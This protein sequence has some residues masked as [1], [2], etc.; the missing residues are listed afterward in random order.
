M[1]VSPI[2]SSAVTVKLN[3]VPAV[4]VAGAERTN[5]VAPYTI[6]VSVVVVLGM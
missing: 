6:C 1:I 4:A 2:A 3:D 5:C